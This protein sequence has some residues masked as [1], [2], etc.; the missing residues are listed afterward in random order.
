MKTL[1]VIPLLLFASVAYAQLT[2]PLEELLKQEASAVKVLTEDKIS[3]GKYQ[4]FLK[5]EEEELA[6]KQQ[7]LKLLLEKEAG[8]EEMKR[9]TLAEIETSLSG[10]PLWQK[11][12]SARKSFYKCLAEGLRKEAHIHISTCRTLHPADLKAEE[13]SRLSV[14]N[15]KNG[16][17]VREVELEKASLKEELASVQSRMMSMKSSLSTIDF[18]IKSGEEDIKRNKRLQQEVLIIQ[19][20]HDIVAC[21]SSMPEINL[22]EKRPFPGAAFKGPFYGVPR[23]NQDGLG[24]C[25]ANTA[26]NLL[27]GAGGGKTDAS[28]LD[29][30]LLYK[31]ANKEVAEDGLDGGHSCNVINEV[32]SRGYCPQKFAPLE[33]GKTNLPFEGLLGKGTAIEAQGTTLFLLKKF[34]GGMEKLKDKETPLSADLLKKGKEIIETLKNNPRIKLPL[35]VARYEVPPEWKLIEAFR[36]AGNPAAN[37]KEFLAEHDRA[38][39]NFYPAYMKAVID[40]KG[41][42]EIFNIYQKMMDPFHRRYRLQDKLMD[43]RKAYKESVKSEFQS[44]NFDLSLKDSLEFLAEISGK[45][46]TDKDFIE[47]CSG[48]FNQGL[49]FLQKLQP[50]VNRL[51]QEKVNAELLLDKDG[52][53]RP[54][55]DLMQLAVAPACVNKDNRVKLPFEIECKDGASTIGAIKGSGK[56]QFEQL[57]M[58]RERVA[59]SLLQGYPLGNSHP[60]GPQSRHINTIVGLRYNKKTD[61]CEYRI[62]ESQ[63]GTSNWHSENDIFEKIDALTEVRKFQ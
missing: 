62:R 54:T 27:L 52:K 44:K 32:R 50:L 59:L 48:Q 24:T 8:R 31:N 9:Q 53:F 34:I 35:P 39:Q 36:S 18:R 38:Y 33:S 28:F 57:R 55:E 22:E 43:M 51:Q 56:S 17:S 61:S 46:V 25:F 63:T 15:E 45:K 40:K 60:T 42:D 37:E 1:F 23:D 10:L 7:K 29:L 20:N 26:R 4:N 58:L 16:R 49:S 30:A 5:Q 2:P 12:Y 47:Y 21:Q 6:E 19:K 14:W 11:A 41:P 3:R 13:Q